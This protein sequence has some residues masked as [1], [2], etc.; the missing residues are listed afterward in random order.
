MHW[1]FGVYVVQ[2]SLQ[3]WTNQRLGSMNK[4]G[5]S[6]KDP[7]WNINYTLFFLFLFFFFEKKDCNF[8]K[9]KKDLLKENFNAVSENFNISTYK[10]YEEKENNL[11]LSAYIFK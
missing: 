11:L 8:I 3:G 10:V 2:F 9:E 5:E 6:M 4:S 1:T 7:W